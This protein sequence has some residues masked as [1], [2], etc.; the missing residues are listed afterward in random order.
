MFFRQ[1]VN[2][3]PGQPSEKGLLT[4]YPGSLKVHTE[5]VCGSYLR[6][7]RRRLVTPNQLTRS[8]LASRLFCGETGTDFLEVPDM[9]IHLGS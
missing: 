7:P 4:V 5:Q 8:L 2:D 9:W 6:H 3:V 1:G